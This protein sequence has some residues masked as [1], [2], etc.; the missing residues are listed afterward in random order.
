MPFVLS[1][2]ARKLVLT[3]HITSSVGWSGAIACF[4]VLAV[5]GLTARDPQSMR[6][7]YLA[8]ELTGWWIIVPLSIVAPLTGVIQSLGTQWGLFRHYWVT[9]KLLITIPSTVILLIHMQPTGRVADRAHQAVF[10]ATDL[11]DLRIQLIADAGLAFLALPVATV[12][13][14]YK[15]A[16]MTPYAARAQQGANLIPRWVKAFGIAALLA[17][18]LF[19][20]SHIA[21]RGLHRHSS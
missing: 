17:M 16:G 14:V 5:T 3:A 7:A 11:F 18:V 13:A 4:L 19:A 9:L 1:A 12:L 2:A 6:A 20:L 15:P 21:G 10:T 8:M